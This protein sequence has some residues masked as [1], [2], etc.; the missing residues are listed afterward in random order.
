MAGTGE[1]WPHLL[2]HY[3]KIETI[4]AVDISTG[5]HELA[6]ERLH[7]IRLEQILFIEDDVFDS[8]LEENSADFIICTFGLKTFNND[9]HRRFAKLVAKVLKPGG[10]LSMIE[11]SDPRGWFFRR[12]YLFHLQRVL[13]LIERIYLKGA[14]DFA[15][16]G[17]Y[18]ANF[19]NAKAFAEMLKDNGLDVEF[20]KYFYGCA[21]GVVGSKPK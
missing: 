15:M 16:I 9:Q 7:K 6:M 20:K 17:Q 18:S 14:Q 21:T 11:A 8:G 13:P 19:G 10:R 1:A 5:M 4:T 2:K 3:P 12:L